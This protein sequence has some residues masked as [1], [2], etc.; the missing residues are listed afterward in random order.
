M[1][2]MDGPPHRP[3]P[4]QP[5]LTSVS[6]LADAGL[7]APDQVAALDRV[8]QRYAVSITPAMAE[9]ID[10]DDANDPIA[11]QFIPS[12][13]E[14]YVAPDESAD[15]IGDAVH[16]IVP[17][18]VHRYPDRA[19]LKITG[20]CPVYCRF[21]FR[22]ETVGPKK[23]GGGDAMLAADQLTGALDYIRRTPALWEIILT[24]GDPLILSARRV[25][26]VTQ[27]LADIPHVKVLR[28]HTRV[29]VVAPERVTP[30]L[31]A[32]LRSSGQ[33]VYVALH[34]NHPRELTP[35]ARSACARLVDG[36][37]VLVSQTVLLKGVNDDV[38]TLDALMRGFVENRIKPYYL[39]H[40][41]R[42][43]GTAGFRTMI[44]EG[45]AL[46]RDLRGRLSG[47]AQPTYVLDLPGGHGKMPIGPVYARPTNDGYVIAD[48][49]GEE[50][51]YC[52]G[53]SANS[54]TS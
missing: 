15:P 34:C 51:A 18:I 52:E 40:G 20:L 35:A 9:L 43:Q 46:M 26:E 6:A 21:C 39:H 12:A 7:I 10:A 14:L 22:R 29:P 49:Q 3:A 28:W 41:D 48:Y 1:R 19:L 54:A 36:G 2:G 33:A 4:K 24:G 50:H 31:V 32:A 53:C 38:A 30:E 42:A 45:Q 17:G 5:P 44:A 47:L 23:A 11:R 25:A 37:I 8:A 27:K 13:A 16:E